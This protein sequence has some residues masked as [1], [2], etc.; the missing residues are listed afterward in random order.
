MLFSHCNMMI[1][2]CKT[3]DFLIKN[4]GFSA[5]PA[6]NPTMHDWNHVHINCE[7]HRLLQHDLLRVSIEMA[8]FKYCFL[9]KKRPFQSIEIRSTYTICFSRRC[10]VVS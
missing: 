4:G 7:L 9:L 1:F 6:R 8:P 10:S 5:N 2:Y 3:D